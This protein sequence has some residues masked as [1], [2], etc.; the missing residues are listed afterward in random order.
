VGRRE[1]TPIWSCL[2]LSTLPLL[3]FSKVKRGRTTLLAVIPPA[4]FLPGGQWG[5]LEG[6]EPGNH[7]LAVYRVASS[8][9]RSRVC[10][11]SVDDEA[12]VC[13]EI[14]PLWRAFLGDIARRRRRRRWGI[15]F[16]HPSTSRRRSAPAPMVGSE[17]SVWVWGRRTFIFT[18]W[19]CCWLAF[20]W[21]WF[22]S[23]V[24]WLVASRIWLFL[25]SAV[26]AVKRWAQIHELEE[27]GHNPG[28][29]AITDGF[30]SFTRR[31]SISTPLQSQSEMGPL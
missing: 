3:Q 5:V 16:L 4:L 6:G 31:V 12:R 21:M 30:I 2:D 11:L 29:W 18:K 1:G 28:L 25:S 20:D 17:R 26:V 23:W 24:L 15:I 27:L 14:V 7:C 9:P 22:Y 10:S 13:R 8:L 19:C